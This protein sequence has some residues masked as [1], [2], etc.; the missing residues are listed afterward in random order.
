MTVGSWTATI[1]PSF[2]TTAARYA[3]QSCR[4]GHG[5]G[6]AKGLLTPS[7]AISAGRAV[8]AF[9]V[10]RNGAGVIVGGGSEQFVWQTGG[11][12]SA[13]I[14]VVVNTAPHACSLG[15]SSAW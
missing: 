13:D 9:A 14:P 12:L 7:R 11:S 3:C 1:G 2:T 6:D 5:Y 8:V 4:A 15:A 10:C